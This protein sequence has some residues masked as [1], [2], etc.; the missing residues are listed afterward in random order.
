VS[1]TSFQK[2]K[3]GRMF[4]VMDVDRDGFVDRA[5]FTH[6]VGALAALRGWETDSAEYERNLGFSL[7]EWQNLCESADA[8]QDARVSREEFLRWADIFL[9]DRDA[10]RAY[11]R[12]DVQLIFDSMDVDGDGKLTVDEYSAYLEVCGVERSAADTFF[13]HADLN[14]DGHVTRAEMSH[15]MEEF[16]LSEDPAAG[17]NFLFG[18][19][20]A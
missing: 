5:D 2:R 3:L 11:A 8:N 14:E 16:L 17:G 6:R 1:L 4:E 18:P 20:E 9:I 7:E 13:A 12:G 10:V 15:A 19:L